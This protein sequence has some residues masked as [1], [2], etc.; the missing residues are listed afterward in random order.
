MFLKVSI[1]QLHNFIIVTIIL[2]AILCS[3]HITNLRAYMYM[4]YLKYRNYMYISNLNI[5]L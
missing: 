1:P 3:I 5:S 2:K 4:M